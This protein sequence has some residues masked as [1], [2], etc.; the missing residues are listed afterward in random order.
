M[1]EHIRLFFAWIYF[2]FLT[3]INP[4]AP[5]CKNRIKLGHA[6]GFNGMKNLFHLILGV[7]AWHTQKINPVFAFRPDGLGKV[8][9]LGYGPV[10]NIENL[11]ASNHFTGYGISNKCHI[12]I[13]LRP[14]NYAGRLIKKDLH[15]GKVKTTA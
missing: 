12:H 7:N 10:S 11:A 3:Q 5:S 14:G 13:F 1:S 6:C 2:Q 8:K 15:I 4:L 9:T